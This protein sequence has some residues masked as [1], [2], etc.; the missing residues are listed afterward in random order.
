MTSATTSRIGRSDI[1]SKLRQLRDQVDRTAESTLPVA[2]L[3]GAVAAAAIVAG[4][5]M[6]GRRRGRKSRTVVEVRRV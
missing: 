5:Y 3:V 2:G 4:A 6:L 1:E